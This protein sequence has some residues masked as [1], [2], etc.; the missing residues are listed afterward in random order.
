[1]TA[2]APPRYKEP[3]EMQ[4]IIDDYFQKCDDG[5]KPYTVCGLALALDLDRKNVL[6]YEGKDKFR[7]TIKKA[8]LK[9]QNYVESHLFG[10]TQVTGAIFNLKNNF[11]WK[12]QHEVKASGDMEIT[13]KRET[14]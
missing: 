2:G 3:E 13:V 14:E 9:I 11:G 5:E 1:M 12:D 10:S 6:V 7:N 8:K 4:A